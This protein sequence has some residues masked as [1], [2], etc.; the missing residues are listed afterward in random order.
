MEKVGRPKAQQ[1]TGAFCT[2]EEVEQLFEAAK[3]DPVEF[4]ISMAAFYGLRRNE[5]M[6]LRW[7]A[8]DFANNTISIDH[9]VGQF[10]AGRK[11]K[12]VSKDRTKT[13]SSCRTMPL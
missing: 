6:G 10:R 4:P 9:T 5:I 12:I 1:F 8:V 7:Q 13:K 3:G 11:Q 2:M